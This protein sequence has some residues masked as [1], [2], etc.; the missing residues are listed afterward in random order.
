MRVIVIEE[1]LSVP[2]A[3][4]QEATIRQRFPVPTSM[5]QEW[6]RRLADTTELRLADRMFLGTP[7]DSVGAS[8]YGRETAAETLH[9]YGY[10]KSVRLPLAWRKSVA[11]AVARSHRAG[12]MSRQQSMGAEV[13]AFRRRPS[14]EAFSALRARRRLSVQDLLWPMAVPSQRR[15]RRTMPRRLRHG[16]DLFGSIFSFLIKTD[17]R[18]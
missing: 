5:A 14:S 15:G 16:A 11:G 3:I 12:P 9:E 4:R 10:S 18:Q 13:R 1:A 6:F 2:G 17:A 7:F 8:R